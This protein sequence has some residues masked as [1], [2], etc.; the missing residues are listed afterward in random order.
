MENQ[1]PQQALEILAQVAAQ[2]K[3]NRAEHELLARSVQTLAQ[4]ITPAP[5]TTETAKTS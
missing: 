1:T 2:F 3:G 5:A 4:A